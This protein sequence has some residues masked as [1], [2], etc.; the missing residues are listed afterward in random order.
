[1]HLS[2][3]GKPSLGYQLLGDVD[4]VQELGQTSRDLLQR[5][6]R[7]VMRHFRGKFKWDVMSYSVVIR[8]LTQL[9][10][11]ADRRGVYRHVIYRWK[12]L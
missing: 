10:Q 1:M 12:E 8:E 9:P 3:A 7:Y 4:M 5:G 2:S 6:R 11:R